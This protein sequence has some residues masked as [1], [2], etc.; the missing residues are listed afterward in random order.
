MNP[1]QLDSLMQVDGLILLM[2]AEPSRT[3]SPV[4]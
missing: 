3:R 1:T 4:T 2:Q